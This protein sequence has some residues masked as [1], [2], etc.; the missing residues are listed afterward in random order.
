VGCKDDGVRVQS[1]GTERVK[2]L[3]AGGEGLGDG[4][5]GVFLELTRC[6]GEEGGEEEEKREEGCHWAPRV[7]EKERGCKV[8]TVKSPTWTVA[9]RS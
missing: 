7:V 4:K 1:R 9:R 5:V 3:G 8:V 6:E 2:V